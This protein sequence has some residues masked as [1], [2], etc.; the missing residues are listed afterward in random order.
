MGPAIE[1]DH[2]GLVIQLEQDH[3][4]S[5][6]L[7]DLIVAVVGGRQ[8]RGPRTKEDDA[9]VIELVALCGIPPAHE[10][11][12]LGAFGCAFLPLRCQRRE[13]AVGR[14]DDQRSAQIQAVWGLTSIQPE[15][16]EVI[17]D[18]GNRARHRLLG[19]LR[20]SFLFRLQRFVSRIELLVDV[21]GTLQRRVSGVG[22]EALKVGLPVGRARG[23]PLSDLA[24][25]RSRYEK[26]THN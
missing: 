25:S 24:D 14:I 20:R 7:H 12:G 9:A 5:R 13:S 10:F 3:H 6:R 22:P 16:S 26:Q 18:V 23:S 21:L 11:G 19:F 8:H 17:M 1:R 2:S 15:L 4:V